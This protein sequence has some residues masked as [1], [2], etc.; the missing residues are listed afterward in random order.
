MTVYLSV[1]CG[2]ALWTVYLSVECSGALWTVSGER[3]EFEEDVGQDV[4]SVA[5]LIRCQQ[6]QHQTTQVR[7]K[8]LA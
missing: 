4:S 7:V 3:D 5:V 1:K 6:L 2:G 8:D